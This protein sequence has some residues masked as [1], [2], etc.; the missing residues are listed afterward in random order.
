M[1]IEIDLGILVIRLRI[2][3]QSSA[4]SKYCSLKQDTLFALLQSTVTNEY[5]VGKN[6]HEMRFS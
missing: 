6:P 3:V 5:K 2:L 1:R 4:V